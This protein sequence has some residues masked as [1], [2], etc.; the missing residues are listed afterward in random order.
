M[1][2]DI[3]TKDK[4]TFDS[5]KDEIYS[6][7]SNLKD[8]GSDE[9]GIIFKKGLSIEFVLKFFEQEVFDELNEMVLYNELKTKNLDF[10][11]Y[12]ITPIRSHRFKE[13]I[14]ALEIINKHY[15]NSYVFD[16]WILNPDFNF[17][18]IEE[19][20][21]LIS[22][23]DFNIDSYQKEPYCKQPFSYSF[24]IND[25][26]EIY[27]KLPLY[28]SRNFDSSKGKGNCLTAKSHN[29]NYDTISLKKMTQEEID[30]IPM[31]K[32]AIKGLKVNEFDI[33]KLGARY[34]TDDEKIAN[35]IFSKS[36]IKILLFL[37]EYENKVRALNDKWETFKEFE[38]INK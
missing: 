13:I 9:S 29:R 12:Y 4:L 18:T 10:N 37:D 7:F 28:F 30:E 8:Y 16:E 26:P 19:Y 14:I 22:Q 6:S 36:N 21:K 33:I 34:N 3:Y 23:P 38:I 2:I 31:L 35:Y 5:I 24:L 27:D 25:N 32:K 20:I 17:L 15:P 1:K 11:G